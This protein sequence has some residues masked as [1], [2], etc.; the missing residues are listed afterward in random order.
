MAR[1]NDFELDEWGFAGDNGVFH[2]PE[3]SETDKNQQDPP[4]QSARWSKHAELVKFQLDGQQPQADRLIQRKDELGE[5]LPDELQ[6]EQLGDCERQPEASGF[7]D[8]PELTQGRQLGLEEEDI[9]W[10]RSRPSRQ[11]GQCGEGRR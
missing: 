3:N 4:A 10:P 1:Y 2:S 8:R 6:Q 5:Q 11:P 9:H 7:F